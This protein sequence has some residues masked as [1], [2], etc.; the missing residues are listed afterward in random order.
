MKVSIIVPSFNHAR[1]IRET[2][3]SVLVQD[4]PDLEVLVF[5][6]GS[7]DG[8]VEILESYGSRI[9][10]VSRSDH[11]QSD[12]INQGL[13]QATGDIL[14]Y[15]NSDD[16]YYPGAISRVVK[17]FK[18][19]PELQCVYGQAL[20]LHE[21]GSPMERYY[22]EPWSYKRLLDVCFICQPSAFWRREVIERFGVFDESLHWAMDYDYWLRL[23]RHIRF[24]Y[25]QDFYIAGSRLHGDTKTLSQRVKVHEEILQ[26]VMRYGSDAPERWL[27][28]LASVIVDDIKIPQYPGEVSRKL[29]RAWIIE[30]A[31]DRARHY[32]I[33]IGKRLLDQFEEW[34]T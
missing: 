22:S 19:H 25:I 10:Y 7:K 27:L 11:G 21:D 18:D 23:G 29:K 33:P 2:L 16:I 9:K 5:D 14:T 3:D 24:D 32:K 30:A 20:H 28:N 1:F 4:H 6:G 8:T 34:L 26:V 17:Q 12:A 31:F 15:L 13:R